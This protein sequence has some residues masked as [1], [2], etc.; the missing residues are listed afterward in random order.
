M[1]KYKEDYF[2]VLINSFYVP[3]NYGSPVI[4]LFIILILPIPRP[5]QFIFTIAFASWFYNISYLRWIKKCNQ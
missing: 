1:Q 3:V 4:L 5:V 2:D